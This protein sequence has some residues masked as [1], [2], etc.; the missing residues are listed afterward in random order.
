MAAALV[1]LMEDHSISSPRGEPRSR[2]D[3]RRLGEFSDL[4][5]IWGQGAPGCSGPPAR[6]SRSSLHLPI[7]QRGITAK[8]F[9]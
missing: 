7:V 5:P 8:G 2:C 3:S 9:G 6:A 4:G 1:I